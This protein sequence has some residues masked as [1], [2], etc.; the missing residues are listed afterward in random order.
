MHRRIPRPLLLLLLCCCAQ[1]AAADGIRLLEDQRALG[2]LEIV[3]VNLPFGDVLVEDGEPG[4]V[5]ATL[6][7]ECDRASEKCPQRAERIELVFASKKNRLIVEVKG[8]ARASATGLAL[9]LRVAAP[10]MQRLGID[11]G[12]G[13]VSV[14]GLTG[15][16]EVDVGVGDVEIVVPLADLR[17]VQIDTGIGVAR[18]TTDLGEVRGSGVVR[19]GLTWSQSVGTAEIEV[20]TGIG[21]ILV[22]TQRLP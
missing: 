14:R 2:E 5:R 9:R 8:A 10:P 13:D 17:M 21:D 6:S 11:L 16:V 22:E 4:I 18:L 19:S 7:I 20:D 12:A 3:D 1:A 15:S